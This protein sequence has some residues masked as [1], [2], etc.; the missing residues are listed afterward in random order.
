MNEAGPEP[1]PIDLRL[2][3]PDWISA[4]EDPQARKSAERLFLEKEELQRKY[5]SNLSFVSSLKSKSTVQQGRIDR[6]QSKRTIAIAALGGGLGVT[7]LA[8]V[9]IR[10]YPALGMPA[11]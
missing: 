3:Y 8:A 1:G 11:A 4:I 7:G 6:L 5:E 10:N 2:G 9:L